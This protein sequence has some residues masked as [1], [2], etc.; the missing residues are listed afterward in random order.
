MMRHEC[1]CDFDWDTG[2]FYCDGTSPYC[3][4][5]TL[6]SLSLRKE[7]LPQHGTPPVPGLSCE[8]QGHG[9]KENSKGPSAETH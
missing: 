1:A 3:P 2:E 4:V 8:S 5:E 6:E 7:G 9:L